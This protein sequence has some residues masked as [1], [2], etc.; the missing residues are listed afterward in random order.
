MMRPEQDVS[1]GFCVVRRFVQY[2]STLETK[3]VQ[4][5]EREENG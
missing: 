5:D 2:L 4:K 1:P 3:I